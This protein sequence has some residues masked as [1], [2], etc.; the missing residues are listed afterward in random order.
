MATRMR[1]YG[2]L[3]EKTEHTS[4]GPDGLKA[5]TTDLQEQNQIDQAGWSRA[6]FQAFGF[7]QLVQFFTK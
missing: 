2:W 4:L 7:P 5:E 1:S 6:K 3:A